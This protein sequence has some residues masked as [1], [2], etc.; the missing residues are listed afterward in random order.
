MN[1]GT[2][3]LSY[4]GSTEDA[5]FSLTDFCVGA[6]NNAT[7]NGT[8]GGTFSIIS[9]TGDGATI[10]ASTGEITN[11]IG[12]TTYTIQYKTNG[13]CPA[14]ETQDVTVNSAPAY[15]VIITN[16]TCGDSNGAITITPNSGVN[17]TDYS[18]DNGITTQGNGGFANLSADD[19]MIYVKD[20]KECEATETVTVSNTDSNDNA[21]FSLTNFCEGTA[22]SAIITGTAGGTFSI[23]SPT[24]DG[25]TINATTGEITN[26]VGG[27][28]YSV[29]YQTNSACPKSAT[30]QV[31]ILLSPNVSFTASPDNGTAPLIV[32]FENT[33]SSSDNFTW[34]FG[35]GEV[36]NNNNTN[37]THTY[38]SIG[39]Y[40]VLLTAENSDGCLDTA[41][42][43]IIVMPS[44]IK[45]SFPNIFTPN[46][47]GKN[48]YFMLINSMGLEE[49]KIIIL[50]RWG[51]VVF[52]D[53]K[54]DFKWNGQ[55]NNSGAD[56]SDGT[57]F[58]KAEFK[59]V[60]GTPIMEH[61][62]IQLTRNK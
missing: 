50:N 7:I 58:Y 53:D 4:T 29:Q 18:I 62:F 39:G 60:D 41:I 10:D 11:G 40:I 24:G 43:Q 38:D 52:E 45:Y 15:A 33:T 61:G 14:S 49:L 47:D 31:T 22:N 13:T 34:D 8:L 32:V 20:D 25:A 46:G 3:T 5:S 16:S 55:V 17:I 37:I 23:I 30:E 2:E 54:A 12:G 27:T 57:Y 51:Q 9:P 44:P 19:Y 21:S 56:C 42:S 48:D 1:T 26:G 28:T 6:T 59:D 36:A 35:D